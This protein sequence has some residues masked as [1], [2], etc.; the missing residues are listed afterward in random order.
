MQDGLR[1]RYDGP[2]AVKD[3]RT[4]LLPVSEIRAETPDIK[5]FRLDL[6]GHKPFVFRP[7]QFVILTT[8]VWNP[9]RQRMGPVNRAFSISTSPTDEDYI[10]I[11][12]RRYPEG[13][14]TP[15]LHDTVRVGD[16]VTVKGP[17]GRFIFKEGESDELILIA[18][19]IGVAPFRSMIRYILARNL[20]VRVSLFYSAR[21]P[22]DFSFA[23]EFDALARRHDNFRLILTVT[24][25][26]AP[27]SGRTGR[28]D[29]EFFR[30]HLGGPTAP[31]YLCGPDSLIDDGLRI[32]RGLGVPD[33]FLRSEK[34]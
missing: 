2:M 30:E 6:A 3:Q 23:A 8:E 15:W 4:L 21:T 10:E 14:I 13:R 9:K 33:A 5:S 32:L 28:F 24:R 29:L 1:S 12:A 7:G 16:R 18:G 19:G 34:W 17:E 26:G 31:Y 27:W 25:P 20:P 22:G 11:A